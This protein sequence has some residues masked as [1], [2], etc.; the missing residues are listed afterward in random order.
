MTTDRRPSTSDPESCATDYARQ[1]LDSLGVPHEGPVAA[2][3]VH[4]AIAWARSGLMWLTGLA[5]GA[6]QMC[7]APLA[8]CADGTLAA[9][10]IV[11]GGRLPAELRGAALLG[12]RAAIAGLARR[13]AISPGGGCRLLQAADGWLAANLVRDDDWLLVPAWLEAT[14]AAWNWE[15]LGAAVRS[16]SAA[17]LVE[18]ARLLGLAVTPMCVPPDT[19]PRW[20]RIEHGRPWQAVPPAASTGS[21][22]DRPTAPVA[23]LVIDLSALWAGPL[24]AHLLRRCGAR[25][26]KVESL[27]RPDGARRGP[28]AFFDLLNAGKASVAL[29][30]DSPQDRERLRQLC[31]RADIVIEASRPRA[32]RQLGLEAEALVDAHPRLTW[33]SITGYGRAEPQAG[34]IAYGDDAG[35]AAG[36]SALMCEV[37]G[38]PLVCGDAIADPLTGLHAAL[39]AL[40]SHRSGGGRLISLALRDVVAHCIAF[41]TPRG[42]EALRRRRDEWLALLGARGIGPSPPRARSPLVRAA[43]LGADNGSMLGSMLGASSARP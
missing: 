12:E 15:T 6:P 32:L 36:L 14:A 41:D 40:Q 3:A 16:R 35:V 26:I 28:E 22:A 8:S 20:A 17:M 33:I 9:L 30:F 31:R 29:D 13:G 19:A 27:R 34:W 21:G 37:S 1:L 18:R 42:G 4:P 23:P 43:A 5:G 24:C 7:P 11:S 10:R 39:A 25:V 2:P 38:T